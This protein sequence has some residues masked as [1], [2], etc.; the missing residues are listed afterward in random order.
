MSGDPASSDP[1]PADGKPAQRRRRVR[2][3]TESL[4]SIVLVLEAILVFFV[5]LTVFGLRVLPPGAALG[6]GAALIVVL[7]LASRTVRHSWGV[8]LG[9]LLQVV[10]LATGLLL[11]A[12]YVVAAIFLA[13]WV[14][15]FVR[16]RQIDA[17]NRAAAS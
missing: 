17:Q 11:P 7:A 12:M 9:W 16:G 2:S 4:L 8:G 1:G 6:G 15:C 5:A 10:V 14:F 13:L 3:L